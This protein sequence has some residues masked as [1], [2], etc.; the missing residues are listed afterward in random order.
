MVNIQ[1]LDGG[2]IFEL[3]KKYRDYGEYAV[4]NDKEFVTSIY[5]GYI[6]SGCKNITT[7]NYCFI[8]SKIDDWELCTKEA[9]NITNL[10]RRKNIKIFGCIPPYFGSYKNDK[11]I[12]SDFSI[13]YEK[14]INIMKN[15]VD[16]YL[17]E[18]SCRFEYTKEIINIIKK[19]DD[20]TPIVVSLYPNEDSK[21][22]SNNYLKL[23]IYGLFLNCCSFTEV[24][25]FYN[26]YI[27]NKLKDKTFGFYCNNIN[28]KKYKIQG[29]I[30]EL[31]K[32]FVCKHINKSDLTVFLSE[33]NFNTIFIGGCCGYGV[34]E[35]KYL[36]SLLTT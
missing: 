9:I 28:E 32:Y 26:C 11:K 3:N 36:I 30:D 24:V 5:E 4:K 35:M 1:F 12:T 29:K 31:E 6:N 18:T 7:S 25:T 23:D 22:N 10:F 27:K 21:L 2:M 20:K 8:P 19:I 14:L 15:Q 17:I 13:F 33:N 34:N 16:Y